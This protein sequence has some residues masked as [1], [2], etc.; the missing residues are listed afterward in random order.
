MNVKIEFDRKMRFIGKNSLS[1][2]T[3]FDTHPSAG[4]EDTA[5]APMEIMLQALGAC[6]AM[7]VIS[8]IRKKRKEILKF[9]IFI[10]AEQNDNHPKY[11]TKTHLIYELTS[12]DA[13]QS[14]LDKAIELSQ[15]NYCSVSAMFQRSGCVVTYEGKI[16]RK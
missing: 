5:G 2:E 6:S 1:L 8:I 7:D 15:K 13:E 3:V 4:G 9:N 10:E 11:F 12:G 16:F 14:E